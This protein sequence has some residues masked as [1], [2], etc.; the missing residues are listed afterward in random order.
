[1][2]AAP[3]TGAAGFASCAGCGGLLAADQRYCLQCGARHGAPRVDPLGALGFAPHVP[4]VPAAA[5]PPATV[6]PSGPSRRM[7]V[8]LAAATLV[9]GGAVGAALGPGPSP[10]LAA[11]PRRIVA[12]V[13]P[14]PA[15]PAPV[16]PATT[17]APPTPQ[18]PADLA[19]ATTDAPAPDPAPAATGT[20]APAPAATTPADT[21]TDDAPA[22][23]TP[24]PSPHVWVVSLTGLDATTAFGDGSPLGDLVARGTLLRGYAPAAAS[25]AANGVALLGGQVPAAD[26]AADLAAC[27]L[28]AGEPSLPAQLASTG[29][30]WR[31]YV[32][33]PA[34]RCAGPSAR[35]AVSLFSGLAD[36]A[37]CATAVVGPEA[38]DADLATAAATP[39]LSLLVPAAAGLDAAPAVHDL[40]GRI[41]AS[42]AYRD[43]GVLLV[44]V[45]APPAPAAPGDPLPAVGALVLSPRATAGAVVDA[46]TGPVAVLDDLEGLLGVSP[47][48][49]PAGAPPGALAGVLAPPT[50][51]ASA[52]SVFPHPRSTTTTWRSP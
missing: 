44:L 31:A 47:L 51:T 40:V 8:A 12:L 21:T 24:A 34:A 2:T 10:S 20:P 23:A 11:A 26:C 48:G 36:G 37:A 35:V 3:P 43:G 14:A 49:A 46:A 42:A 6:R 13:T 30:R 28:P 27:V 9:L 22:A 45:D 19:P 32:E 15:P 50:A 25:A 16:A 33:D 39:A 7:A 52:A 17:A 5:A 18:A 38:L 41:T 4:P 1:M 29:S